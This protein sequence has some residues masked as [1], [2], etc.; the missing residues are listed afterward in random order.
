MRSLLTAERDILAKM[1]E[2][3]MTIRIE[4]IPPV[5]VLNAGSYW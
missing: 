5:K 3:R 4:K 2:R 1:V